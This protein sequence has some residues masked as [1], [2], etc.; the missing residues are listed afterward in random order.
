MQFAKIAD[1][2]IAA[3]ANLDDKDTIRG[4]VQKKVNRGADCSTFV[5]IVYVLK[6]FASL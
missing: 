1:Q 3:C 4:D 5:K 6:I 2:V